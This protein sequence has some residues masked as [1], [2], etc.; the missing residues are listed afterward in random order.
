MKMPRSSVEFEKN[1]IH[2]NE[3]TLRKKKFSV[4]K[5][6]YVIVKPKKN[7]E[8]GITT[9]DLNREIVKGFKTR[10][11]R[12]KEVSTRTIYDSVN[13]LNLYRDDIYIISD[14]GINID[15]NSKEFRY[16]CP[17]EPIDVSKRREL[18]HRGI[19][20]NQIK[21]RQLEIFE[22]ETKQVQTIKELKEVEN[23]G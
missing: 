8:E 19:F 14:W 21:D 20:R 2:F 22:E 15:T 11:F 4:A 6:I 10:G 13:D 7:W 9:K 17:Y 23:D 1:K 18:L 5:E 3:Y 12:R 16:F